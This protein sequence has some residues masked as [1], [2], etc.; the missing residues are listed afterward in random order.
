MS[1]PILSLHGWMSQAAADGSAAAVSYPL[2]AGSV[3][4]GSIVPVLPTGPI[5]AAAAALAQSASGGSFILVVL[6]AAAA[7]LV[8]DV[9]TF[10]VCRTQGSRALNWLV[11]RQNSQRLD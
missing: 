4:V 8:G 1:G 10:T 3:L 11:A 2:M 6:L 7:A 9:V 5:V